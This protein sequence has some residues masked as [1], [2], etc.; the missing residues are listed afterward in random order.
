MILVFVSFE[1]KEHAEKVANFLIDTKFAAC[2]SLLPVTS[3]YVWKKEKVASAEYE[4]I[5]KTTKENF[6]K[7]EKAIRELLSYE[8][9]QLIQVDVT[10]ANASYLQWVKEAID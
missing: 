7:I 5:I 4:A 1:S 3:V 9:P 8:V 2:V 10:K 6:G